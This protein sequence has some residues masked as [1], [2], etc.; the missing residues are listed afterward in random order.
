MFAI[1]NLSMQTKLLLLGVVFVFGFVVFGAISMSTLNTVKV[2]GPQYAEIIQNK[3]L[4]ADVLPPPAYIV[5]SCLVVQLM[6]RAKT[7]DALDE[8]AERLARLKTEFVARQKFWTQNLPESPVKQEL[9]EGS[10]EPAE[11]FFAVVD[12]EFLPL[13]R[14]KD[15]TAASDLI[16]RKL[17][18]LFNEHH[19]VIES[20]VR[21]TTEQAAVKEAEVAATISRL[22]TTQFAVGLI[23]LGA[24]G[25]ITWWLRRLVG[26]QEGVLLEES[27]KLA[28]ISKAQ[29]VVE[30]Q[31][32]GTIL[33]ANQ[34][35]LM[36]LGYSL[37]EIKGKHHSL[38]IDDVVK[39]SQEYRDHWA[40]LNRGENIPGEFER[41]A[42]G[43]KRIVIQASY[44]PIAD[45][46]GRY[47]K[48]VKYA[49]DVTEMAAA[50]REAARVQ[51]MMEQAPI[52]VMFADR[53]L[54]IRYA[55]PA[56]INT[57]RTIENLLP[58]K[59]D[60]L[61]GQ[62]I[63]IFHKRPEHQRKL[64]AD[65][66]N[67]P[68]RANIQLGDETLDLLVSAIYDHNKNYLGS[69]VT[70]EI[71][72]QRLAVEK[73]VKENA[74]REKQ[75]AEEMT[76]ILDQVNKSAATLSASAEE[77]TAV[78]TQM[79]SNADE[80]SAQANVVSA[81]SEQV[82]K[83]VQT[84]STGVEEM[85]AA[86][87]EI[88]KNASDSARVAERAVADA[89]IANTTISKLGES[90]A[91]IGKVLKVITS[92]AEQTNLLALNA[93]IEAARA[94]EAGKGFAVV[95]NE[96]KELAKE[97]AKATEDISHKIEA[98]Q[99]DTLGAVNSIR[100][101][102]DVITQINDISNTIASAV[103]E[104]TA[105]AAE[106]SRNVAE[107]AKG[108]AEIAQNITSVAQA[109]QNTTQGAMN[110]QQ[111]SGE[112]ARMAGELQQ[113]GDAADELEQKPTMLVAKSQAPTNKYVSNNRIG[114]DAFFAVGKA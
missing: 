4:L 96:V 5:E 84:V 12:N 82:S 80:T 8:L 61:V 72:T 109:A 10:R 56:S 90:S 107:A 70:W 42:K 1:R 60:Q 83:N 50:R 36:T 45:S 26:K 103:E 30:F 99:A 97:T 86:I 22:T 21:R 11:T 52:N 94:G 108:T 14:N 20:I 54:K 111:A 53:D 102:G 24:V 87:R 48:V 59:A 15:T 55:N 66:N 23:L 46:T 113:L 62:S 104:Q 105:T 33:H 75:K 17:M 39:N 91:E 93:T 71:I 58:I 31:M 112:L 9:I 67:L 98:I 110:C 81:A 6:S 2:N 41:V 114:T 57:I 28:A 74:A 68:H 47:V 69:M 44:N 89:R 18:P 106:M 7:P 40:R 95:A 49:M 37:D 3:D 76:R 78:S 19:R 85:N 51:S 13:V 63:D 34:N 65:P 64:L 29:A 43:G 73:E 77:L 35:F 32:D 38:F 92:I 16:D 27:T 25:G 100:Q 79:A 88:A 101:I